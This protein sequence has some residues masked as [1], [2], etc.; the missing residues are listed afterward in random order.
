MVA[1]RYA[2]AL[3]EVGLENNLLEEFHKQFSEIINQLNREEGFQKLLNSPLITNK[4][5]KEIIKEVFGKYINPYLLNFIFVVIDNKRQKNIKDIFLGFQDMVYE[6]N[7]ILAVKAVSAV[8]LNKQQINSLKNRLAQQ[9]NK[10][11]IIENKI[12]PSIMGGLV[13]YAE[14]RILDGSIKGKLE[15]LKTELKAIPLQEIG[16][17]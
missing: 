9:F 17:K 3:M 4:E 2:S 7:N 5:K 1:R 6:K 13:I 15:K 12:D 16:V 11:I 8:A 14:N 10:E